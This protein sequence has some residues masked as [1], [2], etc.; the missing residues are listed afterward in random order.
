MSKSICLYLHVHQPFRL[1][2]LNYLELG[3]INNYFEGSEPFSNKEIIDK[4]SQKSYLPTNKLFLKLLKKHPEFKLSLSITGVL[5]EQLQKFSPETLDTFKALVDTGRV[6]ILSETYYHSLASIYSVEEFCAQTF[7]HRNL[8][9][10]VFDYQT[11]CFRNTE[12]IYNDDIASIIK[13]MGFKAILT[14]GWDPVMEWKSSNYCYEA[15]TKKLDKNEQE[16]I[17][18][19]KIKNKL[20]KRKKLKLL[21]KNYKLSDDIAFRFSDKGWKEYP[22]TTEKY[23]SWIKETQGELINLFMDY[24]TFGEHQW[25]DTGIFEFLEDLPGQL[26]AQGIG[27]KTISEAAKLKAKDKIAIKN[28]ISWA[29]MER[30]LSAWNGNK[31]QKES[32]R[33]LYDVEDKIKNDLAQIKSNTLKDKLKD[34]WRKLQTSDHFYYMS[35]KYWSDGD[36]HKYFSPY[37]SPYEAFI[38]FMNILED[39]QQKLDYELE[40]KS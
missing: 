18:K 23:I 21:L 20:K 7:M 31:M 10:S 35:T 29:D 8:I 5:I 25:A 27:F 3:S 19:Y 17:E 15:N 24:E 33:I 38:N 2:K 9:E 36:V 14:E 16:L 22:L 13:E 12:L 40:Q 32:L 26:L 30:D 39:F 6:E 4:V 11:E 1:T 37:N 28:L 34:E